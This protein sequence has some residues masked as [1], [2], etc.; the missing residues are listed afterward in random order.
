MSNPELIVSKTYL[1]V[2]RSGSS[3]VYLPVPHET[4]AQTQEMVDTSS[5]SLEEAMLKIK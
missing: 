4:D 5:D 1:N 2:N 3:P